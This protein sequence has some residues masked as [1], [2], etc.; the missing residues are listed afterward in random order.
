[1]SI[2]ETAFLVSFALFFRQKIGNVAPTDK[3]FRTRPTHIAS[4]CKLLGSIVTYARNS[5]YC[6]NFKKS[7]YSLPLKL[8][9]TTGLQYNN[10]VIFGHIGSTFSEVKSFTANDICVWFCANLQFR[11]TAMKSD[12]YTSIG[13][14]RSTFQTTHWTAIEQIGSNDDIRNRALV[15]DLLKTYWKPVYCYLRHKG[16]DNEEAKDLTQGF[17]HEV[18]LGRELIQ[19]ADRTKGRFRT[20]IL[21][22]LDRYRVSVHRKE[23]AHKRAPQE[24]LI[25][26]DDSTFHELLE[27]VGN[28][29]SEEVFHYTW[30]C[31]LLDRMLQTVETECRQR[32]MAIHWNLFHDR[33]LHP[34]VTG[35]EPLLLKDICRKYGVASTVKASSMIFAV[36]RCFRAAMKRLLRQ[37]VASEAQIS[38]EMLELMNFLTKGRQ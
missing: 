26:L 36:K 31:E 10:L 21:R 9:D 27:A 15:G 13:G 25:S 37:S 6:R 23:T 20:L 8:A 3:R 11:I 19:R 12:E 17:F 24:K 18:V 38:E 33:I 22:A 16:C 32:G 5:G 4:W 7:W 34:I 30:V 35:T 2:V 14:T 29:N 1:M 28:L